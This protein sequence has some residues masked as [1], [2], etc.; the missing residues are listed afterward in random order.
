MTPWLSSR[1]TEQVG[2]PSKPGRPWV[3]ERF[4]HA[5]L[6]IA[7]MAQE[8]AHLLG[9]EFTG[10]EHLL[11]AQLADERCVSFEVL[12]NLGITYEAAR[13]LVV[14]LVGK[15][16]EG[17]P[18]ESDDL[19][20][21][22]RACWVLKEALREAL[23]LG[24]D[25]VDPLHLLLAME[26]EGHGQGMKVLERMG[27]DGRT[28]RNETIRAAF[29]DERMVKGFPDPADGQTIQL[30]REKLMGPQPFV[31]THE[32]VVDL[33]NAANQGQPVLL[34]PEVLLALLDRLKD[35]NELVRL[36]RIRLRR[37]RRAA[38]LDQA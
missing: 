11:L 18:G 25:F 31:L 8:Q 2:A 10:T 38:G 16:A 34:E 9:H 19:L 37:A 36:L 28:L 33:R 35:R 26:Q 21:T 3:S 32:M 12:R 23:Q 13:G 7:F 1:H 29:A 27:V 20:F 17:Q 4:N 14:E 22:P 30:M 24:H 5:S 15:G 6:S